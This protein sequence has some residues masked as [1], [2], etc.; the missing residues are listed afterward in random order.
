MNIF[1]MKVKSSQY[2]VQIMLLSLE[3]DKFLVSSPRSSVGGK[4]STTIVIVRIS[5]SLSERNIF[6][7]AKADFDC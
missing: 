5:C 1:I 4:S 7:K 3:N 6:S 2:S